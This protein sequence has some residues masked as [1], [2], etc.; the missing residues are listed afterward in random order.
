MRP[1]VQRQLVAHSALSVLARIHVARVALQSRS[2]MRPA[3]ALA[4]AM[5]AERSLLFRP[6]FR[7][8]TTSVLFP[9]SVLTAACAALFLAVEQN[10]LPVVAALLAG[11]VPADG[12]VRPDETTPLHAAL[13]LGHLRAAVALLRAGAAVLAEDGAGRSAVDAA[14]ELAGGRRR[15]A[16]PASLAR[17]GG[18]TEALSWGAATNFALGQAGASARA[19]APVGRV[20]ALLGSRCVAVSAARFHS[21]AV[22]ADGVL[23]TWGW[24]RG[25][26]TGH[27]DVASGGAVLLPRALA[28]PG[29]R[30]GA[31]VIAVAAAKHHTLACTDA[32]EVFAWGCNRDGRLGVPGCDTAATPRRVSSLAGRVRVVALAAAN[33]HSVALGADGAVFTWGSNSFGQLGYGTPPG[34]AGSAPDGASA[35]TAAQQPRA[36]ELRGGAV[37]TCVSAA[38]RHTLV[39]TKGGDAWQF[40]H[41]RVTPRRV[42]L[43]PAEGDEAEEEER[44]GF[45]RAEGARHRV[46]AVAAGAAASCALTASGCVLTWHSD[47]E[48]LRAATLPPPMARRPCVAVAAAK[49]RCAAVDADGH[50]FE[51]GSAPSDAQPHGAAAGPSRRR[52][53]SPSPS[54]ASLGAASGLALAE[55]AARAP[56]LPAPA[57]RVP[58]ARRVVA[59]ALAEAHAVA[60]V[61]VT[62]PPSSPCI[63]VADAAAAAAQPG[64]RHRRRAD[65]GGELRFDMGAECT[66]DEEEAAACD[67]D[68]DGGGSAAAPRQLPTLKELCEDA[69][70]SRTAETARHAIPLLE[71]ADALG[72]SRLRAHCIAFT[73][74]NLDALLAAPG[75]VDEL[76]GLHGTLL[77]ELEEAL[78]E[79]EPRKGAPAGSSPSDDA[80]RRALRRA[81]AAS[82][83]LQ[84]LHRLSFEGDGAAGCGGA[85]PCG[86]AEPEAAE[87]AL[88]LRTLRRKLTA[89]EAL[90]AKHAR[91]VG[92]PLDA[93]QRAKL[94]RR[95]G[96]SAAVAALE[97]GDVAAAARAEAQA[98]AA[99]ATART[100]LEEAEAAQRA[101]PAGRRHAR[102]LSFS[103]SVP[104]PMPLPHS[105]ASLPPRTPLAAAASAPPALLPGSDGAKST[106]RRSLVPPPVSPS[107]SSSAPQRRGFVNLSLFLSGALDDQPAPEPPAPPPAPAA[108]AA[109]SW[110]AAGDAEVRSLRDIQ[111]QQR[112]AASAPGRGLEFSLAASRAPVGPP[113][114]KPASPAGSSTGTVRVPLSALLPRPAAAE[115]RRWDAPLATSAAGG[116][117]SPSLRDIQAQQAND[118]SKRRSA[119]SPSPQ[120][121]GRVTVTGFAL[122]SSSPTAVQPSASGSPGLNAARSGD[123]RWYIP[124]AERPHATS[125][126]DILQAEAEAAEEAAEAAAAVAAVAAAIAAEAET[127]KRAHKPR[128]R[129]STGEGAG[130][131][132][133]G[134]ARGSARPLPRPLPPQAS[135]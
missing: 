38:K 102:P 5:C 24:G 109:P 20:E 105:P 104:P 132:A 85:E 127:Q 25:G 65:N 27:A 118:A 90:E 58:G 31:R 106:P 23:L 82:A 28:L 122:P 125:L 72:A 1:P 134:R 44:R 55:A 16:P 129:D 116:P 131:R 96:L 7:G 17:A 67:E 70:A 80:V 51:W 41:T 32:G 36:V 110:R 8:L 123:E 34:A 9:R 71:A 22:T 50:V 111:A 135:K 89:V 94:A 46:I 117:A 39:A 30:P 133:G 49:R 84:R 10:D 86:A 33:R 2:A 62:P 45:V 63:R 19:N 43:P 126:R 48:A 103:P 59:L 107:P 100:A 57:V 15:L 119:S 78:L 95:E 26:R 88:L 83:L 81:G 75:G 130:A 69:L 73:L 99:A 113:Q 4:R 108:P 6:R 124:D 115:P 37:A 35:S 76:C 98:D 87:R 47:D 11:G 56:G 42:A 101:L 52:S 97:R 3:L 54:S 128:R 14:A 12:G 79:R 40:G 13:R 64:R 93:A 121:R 112:L 114:P 61:A 66:S 68:D 29:T 21:A 74:A 53:P 77:T 91:G 92:A 60:L 18:G 120:L